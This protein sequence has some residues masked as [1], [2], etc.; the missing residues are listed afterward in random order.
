MLLRRY[1][2]HAATSYPKSPAT[3][4]A[5]RD[6]LVNCGAPAGR[7]GYRSAIA[8][9]R[10]IDDARLA[11]ARLFPRSPPERVVFTA[12]GTD[13]LNLALQGLCRPGDHLITSTWEHNSVL[14][15]LRALEESRG[16]S[17]TRIAPDA[18]GLLDPVLVTAA[19]RPETRCVVL[20]HASN[21]IGV[22]QPLSDLGAVVRDHGALLL[23]DAAQTA[24]H[25][26][27]NEPTVDVW[28][29]SGH[30]GLCGPL[31]TGILWVGP[32]AETELQSIR[33]GGTG[34]LSEDDHHP[35]ALPERLEAGNPN[36]P[37]LAGLGA[38]L[39]ETNATQRNIR[40]AVEQALLQRLW[41]GLEAI[42]GLT[43]QGPHPQATPRLGIV[44]VTFSAFAPAEAATLLDEHF[45]IECRAG[46]HCAPG[47]HRALGTFA[48]GGTVRFSLGLTTTAE[49]VD[50]V[51]E[52][53]R[54]LTSDAA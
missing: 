14:R 35:T 20:Q 44:S 51:V 8:A 37:G 25:L 6:Y 5:V 23:V 42:K 4:A 3:L 46:L 53:C 28:A 41:E 39:R 31:G 52:A 9:G 40:D 22:I 48:T 54:A 13:S 16:I 29:C 19:L 27:L 1:L 33:W 7:G 26:E 18:H 10:I 21:V 24:G 30:K 45:Q 49:D 34:T 2:D 12:N 11:A 43:L 50:A 17:V 36:V 38:A 47:V 32:R 15:P